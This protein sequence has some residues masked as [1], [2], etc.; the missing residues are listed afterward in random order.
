[1]IDNKLAELAIELAQLESRVKRLETVVGIFMQAHRTDDE[2]LDPS[3][4][5]WQR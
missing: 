2:P 5:I 3:I 1:M 4:P